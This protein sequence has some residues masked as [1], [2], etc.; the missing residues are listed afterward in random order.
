MDQGLNG[1][2]S[3]LL[4]ELVTEEP[5]NFVAWA[6]LGK[7]YDRSGNI[8]GA[9]EAYRKSLSLKPNQPNVWISFGDFYFRGKSYLQSVSAY[10]SALQHDPDNAKAHN[11]LGSAYKEMGKLERAISLCSRNKD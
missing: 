2:A 9:S 7:A 8:M 3:D 5:G 4:K 11:N 1:R 10:Q 6:G